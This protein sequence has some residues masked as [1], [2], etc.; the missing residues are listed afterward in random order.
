MKY[1]LK[2]FGRG[3]GL[4]PWTKHTCL[5]LGKET[6]QQSIIIFT[7]II[8]KEKIRLVCSKFVDI[9]VMGIS[10]FDHTKGL[11][12]NITNNFIKITNEK[13]LNHLFILCFVH[14]DSSTG[15][16]MEKILAVGRWLDHSFWMS[17][18]LFSRWRVLKGN[19]RGN[20]CLI[21]GTILWNKSHIRNSSFYL[22]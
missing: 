2:S 19:I 12:Y 14:N 11:C 13:L 18:S 9:T 7:W 15:F 10:I 3:I 6:Y 1:L 5:L 4:L 20:N 16:F 22:N 8:P 17:Q 21:G